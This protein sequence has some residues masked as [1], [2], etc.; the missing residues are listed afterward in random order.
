MSSIIE[1]DIGTHT[2]TG[3]IV[4]RDLVFFQN[5]E[6]ADMSKPA[7]TTTAEHQT[8]FRSFFEL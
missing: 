4:D 8:N 5:L 2:S 7:G 3:D 1:R 6:Y